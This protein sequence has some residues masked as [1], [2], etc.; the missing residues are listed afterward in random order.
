M[1]ST[2]FFTLCND[3]N[4][5]IH[6][7]S[8]ILHH[9]TSEYEDVGE[10]LKQVKY[11]HVSESTKALAGKQKKYNK[12]K[13]AQYI[14]IYANGGGRSSTRPF[15]NDRNVDPDAQDGMPLQSLEMINDTSNADIDWKIVT[16][17]INIYEEGG[18]DRLNDCIQKHID[19]LMT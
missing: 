4:H 14:L 15:F 11:A 7:L 2:R 18:L 1:G 19:A 10:P 9:N 16:P 13:Q 6:I 5:L 3:K 17:N 8:L 12:F